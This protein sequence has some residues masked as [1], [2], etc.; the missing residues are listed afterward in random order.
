[1]VVEMY[2]EYCHVPVGFIIDM[3]IDKMEPN[4]FYRNVKHSKDCPMR[5]TP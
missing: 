5:G 4:N 2:C 3:N 1:M